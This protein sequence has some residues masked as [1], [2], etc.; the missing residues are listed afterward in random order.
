MKTKSLTILSVLLFVYSAIGTGYEIIYKWNMY[1]GLLNIG[2]PRIAQYYISTDMWKELFI[3]L[4]TPVFACSIALFILKER[5]TEKK[6]RII[7]Y[8]TYAASAWLIAAI[9]VFMG[10]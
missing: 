5:F 2:G 10:N 3:N 9:A 6:R 4:S 1:D 7:K 8:G